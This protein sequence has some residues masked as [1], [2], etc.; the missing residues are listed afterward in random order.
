MDVKKRKAEKLNKEF[1]EEVAVVSKDENLQ[2]F[3]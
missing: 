1:L 3:R 2:E